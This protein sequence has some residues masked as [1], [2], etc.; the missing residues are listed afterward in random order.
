MYRQNK[1]PIA[2]MNTTVPNKKKKLAR[3]SG[4]IY[5]LILGLAN[6]IGTAI[7]SDNLGWKDFVILAL[8]ATP[9]LVNK[10]IYYLIF[11][12]VSVLLWGSLLYAVFNR[13][14]EFVRGVREYTNPYMSSG[15]AF[16]V[17]YLFMFLSIFFSLCLLYAGRSETENKTVT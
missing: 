9:L 16:T 4:S 1:H 11:G 15:A 5:F 6:V 2:S 8:F 3:L 10:K 17:G 13:H 12:A 7:Y 14:V